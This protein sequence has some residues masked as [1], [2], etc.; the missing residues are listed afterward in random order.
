MWHARGGE[1]DAGRACRLEAGVRRVHSQGDRQRFGQQQGGPQQFGQQQQLAGGAGDWAALQQQQ[2]PY[3]KHH[4][5]M[6]FPKYRQH[7][8]DLILVSIF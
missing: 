6:L 4:D 1:A 5:W 2:Q 3:P 7:K 8:L